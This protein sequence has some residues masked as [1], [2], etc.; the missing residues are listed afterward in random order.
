MMKDIAG[1][2]TALVTKVRKLLGN[3]YEIATP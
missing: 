3:T 2:I 1:P